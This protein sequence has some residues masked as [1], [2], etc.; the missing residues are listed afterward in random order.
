MQNLITILGPT[1]TG[2]TL[3]AARLASLVNGEVISA[4]SRQVYRGMDI[5]TGKDLEDYHVSGSL[6]PYHLVDIVDPGYEYNIFE[7]QNDFIRVF[8]DIINRDKL[9]IFCGGSGL[10]LDSIIRN[11]KM[12]YV[13]DNYVLRSE[14]DNLS[15]NE[16]VER[17]KNHKDLHNITDT[18][19]RDRTIRAIEIAEFHEQYGLINQALE[20]LNS[21]NFGINFER[22]VIKERITVRLKYRLSNG[23]IEEVRNLLGENLKPEQLIFYGLEYKLVTQYIT[24]ELSYDEMFNKL[25]I[26]IHQ[27]SKRQMTWF[28]RMEKKGVKIDW[29]DGN[30][31]IEKKL[32]YILIKMKLAQ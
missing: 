10:Y 6:V 8:T 1:A 28:R 3:L 20:N 24:G 22:S 32:E 17:L 16:L 18:S 11:Y 25:N 7:F 12:S 14:L 31:P 15:D 2:K 13:P 27:F 21:I 9:P 19:L 29:I 5:G 23:L 4:D 26:A 30:L